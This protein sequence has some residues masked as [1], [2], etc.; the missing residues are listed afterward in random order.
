VCALLFRQAATLLNIK[1]IG[2]R[3]GL[4]VLNG[5]ARASLGAP[6]TLQHGSH[7]RHAVDYWG[8]PESDRPLVIFFYGGGWTSGAR[9]D[10]RFVADTFRRLG[11][12]VAVPDYRL[13][14][15]VR[16]DEISKDA[17]AAVHHVLAHVAGDRPIVLAGHSAGAQIAMLLTMNREL[18]GEQADRVS[19]VIGL[20]GPYDF[21]PFRESLHEDLFGPESAWP[22]S[23]PIRF[24]R[25]DAP[26]VLLL[27][28]QED[29]R[30]RP[31]QSRNL[32]E[33]LT[34]LGVPVTLHLYPS[35]GHVDI[36]LGFAAF[37]RHRSKVVDDLK[38]FLTSAL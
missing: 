37:I 18:L 35:I 10:Y 15:E 2:Q 36:I 16:F 19:A 28:G 23:Q 14:P 5:L 22:A 12:D 1:A 34:P 25:P 29:R 9:R 30:V 17:I 31:R 38:A 11:C 8:E 32:A 20:A 6:A 4:E 7:T 21:M 3:L 26:P 24:A 33:R 13:Y 27:H